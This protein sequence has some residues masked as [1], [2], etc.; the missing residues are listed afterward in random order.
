METLNFV[1]SYY[2]SFDTYLIEP[3]KHG[4]KLF[5]RIYEK[6]GE[7]IVGR[8]PIYLIRKS[9]SLTGTNYKSARIMSKS[10]F[11]KEKHKLPVIISHDYGIPCVFF[12][13]LSPASPNN[14]WVGLHAIINIRRHNDCTEITLKDG[15]EMTLHVHYTSFCSQYVSAS[16]LQ[17]Y[18]SNQRLVIQSELPFL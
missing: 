14:V 8:K 7:V 13:L 2:V 15:R 12:P 17:K 10:F 16:M 4:D 3:L 1:D 6:G 11:G 18:A 5:S 9:C